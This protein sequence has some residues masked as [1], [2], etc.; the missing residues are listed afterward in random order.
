MTDEQEEK[1][2]KIIREL[3][4]KNKHITDAA[5]ASED[6][7]AKDLETRIGPRREY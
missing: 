7:R 4:I 1:I 2:K 5:I 3:G 6:I